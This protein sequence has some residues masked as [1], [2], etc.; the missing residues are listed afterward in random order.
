MKHLHAYACFLEEHSLDWRHF[1]T[2]LSER[3]VVRFRGDLLK[4]IEQGN[5]ASSTARSRINAVVQFYRH[6]S[7]YDFVTPT[8]PMWRDRQVVIRYFD[9]AGFKRS[10]TRL[11][12]DLAIP[13]RSVVGVRLEDGL[14]PLSDEHMTELLQFTAREETTELHLMLSTGF[15]TGAR[16]GTI[17]S[18]R[19]EN[20]EQ[21]RQD[22]YLN[23]FFLIR[24]GPGTGVAT[25]LNVEGDLLVPGMLLD[26]LKRYAYSTERLKREEKAPQA[27]RSILFLT[28]RGKK[29]SNN[30]VSRLMTGLRRSA[31]SANLRFMERFKF[32]Q[33]RA[34]YGTWL[35]KLALSVAT[36]AA[37]IEFVKNAMLHKR[38]STTF[39]YVKF[40]ETN[41][42]KQAVAQAFHEVFTG[43]RERNWDTFDA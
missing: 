39:T 26:E 30:S 11:T 34:T 2:R 5:L 10:L 8:T 32:H 19:I 15:F 28:C 14:L 43:L 31:V 1:P 16:L 22:P 21:A 23:G 38:E 13:N 29:Y 27:L 24:V 37:A 18:L 4:L 41:K 35:M 12:T 20:L 9:S 36:A 42:G 25:K 6:A 17:T 7:A 33:T 40:L 3:A